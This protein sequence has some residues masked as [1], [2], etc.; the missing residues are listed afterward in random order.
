MDYS[1]RKRPAAK[2]VKYTGCLLPWKAAG[3]QHHMLTPAAS[4]ALLSVSPIP[5]L[6]P[7]SLLWRGREFTMQNFVKHHE[8]SRAKETG[9]DKPPNPAE[10]EKKKTTDREPTRSSP[11]PPLWLPTVPP[12]LSTCD[13]TRHARTCAHAHTHTHTHAWQMPACLSPVITAVRARDKWWKA[14]DR[15]ATARHEEV[16]GTRPPTTHSCALGQWCQ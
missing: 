5:T 2:R 3:L 8:R 4:T 16:Q 14:D 13:S 1:S 12:L 6:L 10:K 11:A 7:R 9:T 15:F